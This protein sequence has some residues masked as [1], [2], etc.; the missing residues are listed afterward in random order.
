MSIAPAPN[1]PKD[2]ISEAVVYGRSMVE[3]ERDA[4]ALRA[5]AWKRKG[6]AGI[7]LPVDPFQIAMDLGL[8]V[9]TGRGMAAEIS[10]VLVK[11]PGYVDPEILL[12]AEDSRNRQ[13]FTCAHELGHY[14]ERSKS[15]DG[16]AWKH[17]DGR[18]LFAVDECGPV[19]TYANSFAAELL[20]P[21]GIVADWGRGTNAPVLALEF[22]VS[23]DAMRFRLAD[24]GIA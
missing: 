9:Y 13:R 4:E 23:A 14:I 18:D 6:R 24:L 5:R 15:G 11:E 10:G 7:R 2:R 12:N 19:E 17:V 21:R 22:G 16:G 20:M 8:R 3:A 1:V